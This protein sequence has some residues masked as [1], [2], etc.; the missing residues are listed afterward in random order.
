[1]MY[2]W[3]LEAQ[4]HA[5]R[6]ADEAL[7]IVGDSALLLAMKGQLQWN[8]ANMNLGPA[9][10]ALARGSAFVDQALAI[11]PESYLAIFV[12]GLVAGG[13]GQSVAALTDLYDAHARR[14]GDANVLVEMCRYS[15]SSGLRN[16][17]AYI[18]EGVQLDPLSPSC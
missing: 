6:L 13:R 7:R 1:M 8:Q 18:E 16:H 12:R 2:H 10:E 5:D 14:P 4:Q 15:N 11:D 17:W 9:D 3:T